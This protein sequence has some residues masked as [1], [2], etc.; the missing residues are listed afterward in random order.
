V[1][2]NAEG[3]KTVA[4]MSR[5]AALLAVNNAAQAG[6]QA[7]PELI[8]AITEQVY[9]AHCQGIAEAMNQAV[10][11]LAFY[12]PEP[13]KSD[14]DDDEIVRLTFGS[15]CTIK[16]DGYTGDLTCDGDSMGTDEL[17]LEVGDA[18]EKLRAHWKRLGAKYEPT[19]EAPR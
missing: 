11:D 15:D 8:E 2:V 12:F 19:D 5:E 10:G 1:A 16:Y 7:H 6:W 9:R 3:K 14:D 4:E 18:V 13:P 17:L